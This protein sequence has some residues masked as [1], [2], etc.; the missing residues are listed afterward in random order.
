MK[1]R[2]SSCHPCMYARAL[3]CFPM[4]I[5]SFPPTHPH[6]IAQMLLI[7]CHPFPN[8]VYCST[9]MHK[10]H[11]FPCE[12]V[13]VIMPFVYLSTS[14]HILSYVPS[15]ISSHPPS[16]DC[17]ELQILSIY[18]TLFFVSLLS[19][20]SSRLEIDAITGPH[21]LDFMIESRHALILLG[22]RARVS[23]KTNGRE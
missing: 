7:S 8:Q 4:S 10:H 18:G 1:L 6:M 17:S 12:I 16:R 21:I 14:I 2:R 5:L 23:L 22:D 9:P 20:W 13:Y 15:F 3:T 11:P 19:L